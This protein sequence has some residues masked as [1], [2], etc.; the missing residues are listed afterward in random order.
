MEV[1]S[2]R[3]TATEDDL[4]QLFSRLL[5][6]P[7]KLRDL[8]INVI[9][10]GLSLTG[11]YETILPIPF[12]CFWKISVSDRKIVARLSSIKAVGVRLDILKPYVLNALASN[13]NILELR[14]ESV[15]L[16]LDRFLAQ[17]TVPIRT[18]LTSLRC[19][20]AQLVIEC[21]NIG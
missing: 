9:P 15:F 17:I 5:T 14:G 18:N 6:P 13:N 10:D 1:E 7:P 2:L 16:D 12:R 4:N 21:G 3:F 8:R 11:I 20:G 19:E